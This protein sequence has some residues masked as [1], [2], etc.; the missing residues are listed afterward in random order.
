MAS[1][2]RPAIGSVWSAA[3][4]RSPHSAPANAGCG[5]ALFNAP[6][7]A[8]FRCG[9]NSIDPV[10]VRRW[11][12]PHRPATG[13]FRSAPSTRSSHSAPANARCGSAFF[14]ATSAAGFRWGAHSMDPVVAWRWR[15]PHRP[16][17]GSFWSAPSTR[18]PHSAPANAGCGSALFNAPSAAGF[19]CGGDSIDPVVVRRWRQPHRPAMGSFWSAAATRSPHRAPVNAGCGRFPV[20]W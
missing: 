13:S 12:Q 19:R 17:M 3:A 18:S 4:T 15:Q 1:A 20:R 10:V 9:G 5:S 2:A 7:A 8:G 16:A 11:R 6:S 14:N